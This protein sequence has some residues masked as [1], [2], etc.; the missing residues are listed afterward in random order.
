MNLLTTLL[1][2]LSSTA[3]S[4]NVFTV[5]REFLVQSFPRKLGY[6]NM[7]WINLAQDTVQYKTP[8]NTVLNL[9]VVGGSVIISF[10]S[11]SQL[12]HLAFP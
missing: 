6:D 8:V 11:R 5:E 4:Q 7:N 9:L 2:T 1:H 3:R 10:S 12:L